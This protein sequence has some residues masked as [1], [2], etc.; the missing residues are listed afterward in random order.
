M[1][2][3]TVLPGRTPL[4]GTIVRRRR[5]VPSATGPRVLVVDDEAPIRQL[6]RRAFE[7][8]VPGSRRR[9]RDRDRAVRA[10]DQTSYP[11]P[12][13]ARQR[14]RELIPSALWSR[15]PICRSG[16][17][18]RLEGPRDRHRRQDYVGRRSEGRLSRG[19]RAAARRPRRAD[20][21][22]ARVARSSRR[23]S[24]SRDA[25]GAPMRVS[26]KEFSC[27]DCMMHV[28]RWAHSNRE[29]IWGRCTRTTCSICAFTSPSCAEAWR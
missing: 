20:D 16:D 15:V 5:R 22:R 9:R 13:P 24:P 10:G 25:A 2:V 12:R 11:R 19:E 27:C 4:A 14:G 23:R 17:A 29:R 18:R 3:P 21:D 6:L 1:S 8:H 28:G 26:R 7:S